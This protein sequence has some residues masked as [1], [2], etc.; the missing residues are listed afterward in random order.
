MVDHTGNDLFLGVDPTPDNSGQGEIDLSVDGL[1]GTIEETDGVET[2]VKPNRDRFLLG[3]ANSI[4]YSGLDAKDYAFIGDFDTTEDTIVLQGTAYDYLLTEI[5]IKELRQ[6]LRDLPE[7]K[8]EATRQ[9]LGRT[10][11][12]LVGANASAN[13]LM[14]SEQLLD[15]FVEIF[16]LRLATPGNDFVIGSTISI[17]NSDPNNPRLGDLM[18]GR[19]GNDSFLGVN[20]GADLPGQG[21]IDLL[22]GGFDEPIKVDGVGTTTGPDNDVFL[23]GDAAKVYYSGLGIEDYAWITDLDKAED[24]IQ[25]HG[26]ADDYVLTEIGFQDLL[27]ILPELPDL[28]Q[29]TKELLQ[30][31]GEIKATAILLGDPTVVERQ[32]PISL[33]DPNYDLIGIVTGDSNLNLSRRYFEFVNTLPSPEPVEPQIDQLGTAGI[34]F[35]FGVT[36]DSQGNIYQVGGTSSNLAGD[37]FGGNDIF[38]RKLDSSGEELFVQQFGTVRPETAFSVAVDS[39]DNVFVS[40]VTVGDLGAPNAGQNDA[41]IAKFDQNGNQQWIQQLGSSQRD[42]SFGGSLAVDSSNNLI[43]GG[44]TLGDLGGSNAGEGP[45]LWTAKFDNDGNELWR[46][47]FGTSEFDELIGVATD[48]EDNIFMTGWTIGDLGGSNAGLYDAWIA[49]YDRDGNQLWIDQFGTGDFEFSYGVATDSEGN[50]YATGYTLGDLGGSNAGLYDNWVTKYDRDGNQLW[51]KQFGSKG[52]DTPF[53][54]A[55]DLQDN[56]LVGGYTDG[57]LAGRRANAGGDDAWAAKLDS[58]G[59]LLNIVQFGTAENESVRGISVGNANNVWLTGY[60]DGS[61]GNDATQGNADAWLAQLSATDLA[62]LG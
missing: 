49:K 41:W 3:D 50:V 42:N 4:Y 33:D 1:D 52:S 7:Q 60:T 55:V 51:L 27:Q 29:E 6:V 20:P 57:S 18:V 11:G 47:Q 31:L 9:D 37:N 43:L 8:M 54:I 44:Y 35:S 46:I 38:L 58:D 32:T 30:D 2:S 17:F 25:L 5:G 13:D 22:V 21:E 15:F 56:L 10:S 16:N 59:N 23:L 24:I 19:T 26:S 48:R 45:D 40:G 53:A 14:S 39:N 36:T 34:D 28:D 12:D 62:L 61:L